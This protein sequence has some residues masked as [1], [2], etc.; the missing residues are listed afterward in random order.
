MTI[1]GPDIVVTITCA[2]VAEWLASDPPSWATRTRFKARG[3]DPDGVFVMMADSGVG[4]VGYMLFDGPM[5]HLHYVETRPDHRQ[6]GV[7]RRLWERVQDEITHE[8]ITAAPKTGEG[9]ERLESWGFERD[10]SG[11]WTWKRKA[12]KGGR[13]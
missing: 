7:A 5:A 11:V 9:R 2:P 4:P 12:H 3:L 6:R 13:D 8:T 10:G 1:P